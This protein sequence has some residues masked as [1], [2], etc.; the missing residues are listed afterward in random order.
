[1]NVENVEFDLSV[2]FEVFEA[3][4]LIFRYFVYSCSDLYLLAWLN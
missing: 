4:I 1:M 3:L 2:V